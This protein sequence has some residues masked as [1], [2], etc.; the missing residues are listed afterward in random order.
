MGEADDTEDVGAMC[1]LLLLSPS[2]RVP[3]LLGR[4]LSRLLWMRCSLSDFGIDSVE[5]ASRLGVVRGTQVRPY[6]LTAEESELVDPEV[7]EGRL[8]DAG[9]PVDWSVQ[10]PTPHGSQATMKKIGS[11][12]AATWQGRWL[13][14]GLRSMRWATRDPLIAGGAP[15]SRTSTAAC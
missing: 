13:W 15:A 1:N 2:K 10:R 6:V 7:P 8:A 4:L 12:V 9:E 3:K 5:K 14:R 11:Q